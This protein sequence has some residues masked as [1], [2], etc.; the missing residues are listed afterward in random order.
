MRQTFKRTFYD[1]NEA[2][3][4]LVYDVERLWALAADLPLETI[5]VTAV[6]SE[7]DYPYQWFKT[8]KPSPREVARH[9]KL[10]YEADLSYPIILS[11]KGL[12]MDGIHRIAKAWL[13]SLETIEAVRFPQDP[14]PD[15]VIPSEPS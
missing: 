4:T 15:F 1:M 13:L 6:E 14:E 5:P 9:A 8:K 12:V 7:L 10:I 11:A 2:G 3:D